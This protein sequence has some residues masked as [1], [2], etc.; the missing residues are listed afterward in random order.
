MF[1]FR[2]D[3]NKENHWSFQFSFQNKYLFS[4]LCFCCNHVS[5]FL[6][7]ICLLFKSINSLVFLLKLVIIVNVT[8]V[9]CLPIILIDNR[10]LANFFAF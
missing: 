8:K 2:R 7:L 6:I 3:C 5:R 1:L 10:L 4:F 9:I